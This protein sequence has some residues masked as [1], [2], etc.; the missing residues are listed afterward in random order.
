MVVVGP[1][2]LDKAQR[3]TQPVP[4]DDGR[5]ATARYRDGCETGTHPSH[6]GP[7]TAVSDCTVAR[8]VRGHLESVGHK[9]GNAVPWLWS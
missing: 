5:S 2:G 4:D 9:D 3:F 6:G 8:S 7:R 1:L